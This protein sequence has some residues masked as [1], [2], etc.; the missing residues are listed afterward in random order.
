MLR[1]C[2]RSGE[3]GDGRL[4]DSA[5]PRRALLDLHARAVAAGGFHTLALGEDRAVYGW[6]SSI[7]LGQ[8]LDTS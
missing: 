2:A 7:C 1:D 4:S 5:T 3:L 8:L 6:G